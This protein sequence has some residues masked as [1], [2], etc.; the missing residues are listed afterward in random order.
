MYRTMS[1]RTVQAVHTTTGDRGTTTRF[2]GTGNKENAKVVLFSIDLQLLK[3]YEKNK[4]IFSGFHIEFRC[5]IFN[6]LPQTKI[7]SAQARARNPTQR[8]TT[9]DC[10]TSG[11]QLNAHNANAGRRRPYHTA[12]ITLWC[13][14]IRNQ[15][16]GEQQKQK[17][18]FTF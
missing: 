16:K 10:G 12:C 9:R 8:T 15:K 4:L 1:C 11:L 13:S 3:N 5:K 18:L 6:W 7:L 17:G 2:K 14:L